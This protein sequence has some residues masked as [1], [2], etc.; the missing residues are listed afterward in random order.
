[1]Q[2]LKPIGFYSKSKS[3]NYGYLKVNNFYKI[4]KPFTDNDNNLHVVGEKWQYLGYSFLPY[5]EGLQ[6][7]VSFDGKHEMMIPLWLLLEE[8]RYIA[9][10]IEQFIQLIP[11]IEHITSN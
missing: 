11:T 3:E 6:W 10:N 7:I 4:I 2:N 5:D 1:M 9:N 8:Q